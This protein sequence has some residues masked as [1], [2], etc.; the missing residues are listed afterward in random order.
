MASR[1]EALQ[2]SDSDGSPEKPTAPEPVPVEP[3]PLDD[4]GSLEALL[5]NQKPLREAARKILTEA[6]ASSE[7][8]E[9]DEDDDREDHEDGEPGA[10]EEEEQEEGRRQKRISKKALQRE[11]RKKQKAAKKLAV[12]EVVEGEDG[13]EEGEDATTAPKLSKAEKK[14]QQEL[15]KKLQKQQRQEEEKAETEKFDKGGY[16]FT[17]LSGKVL[18]RPASILRAPDSSMMWDIP[19]GFVPGMR[20]PAR[21]FADEV[22][23]Q[24]VLEEISSAG[25]GF[26]PAVQQLANVAT[27]PGI[28]GCSLGMPD[29][30]SGYGF[31]VGSV[32]AIDLSR[33]EA[34]VSPGGVGFDINCGVRLLR[35]NLSEADLKGNKCA[36]L[37]TAVFEAVPAGVG[38]EGNVFG[39]KGLGDLKAALKEGMGWAL[40]K[41]LCWPKDLEK[42]EENGAMPDA[43]PDAVSIRALKRGSPQLGTLGSGNH[44]L[45]IQVVDEVMDQ[46]AATAMGLQKGQV[47]VMIHCGSR[48]L[49]HQLCTD[50]LQGME[51]AM[52][53]QGISIPDRQLCCVRANSPQGEQYLRGMAAAANYAFVNRTIIAHSVRQAFSNVFGRDPKDLGMHM[54]YDVSHNI[55]KKEWHVDPA[56]GQ[57]K[58]TLVHRKGATRAFPPGHEDLPECY[59]GCGQ[60]VLIGGSMGTCSYVLVGGPR[61]MELSFGSTCHGAGRRL[62]RAESMRTLSSSDVLA[63]LKKQGIE[64]RVT[65]QKL[66]A[67]EADES[68]KDVNS[69]V[70]TCHEV[71][72]SK[73]VARMRP[74][75]VIKG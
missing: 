49:G 34:V 21:F 30:H 6:A 31:A 26:L 36:R 39:G 68:Y 67:E 20:A 69:V 25:G 47:C 32:A 63:K 56:D 15:D 54:V 64:V 73:L 8:E 53:Q 66:I 43:D 16:N 27:L 5:P 4:E 51:S 24:L 19:L 45:E 17:K 11:E 71:G 23:S 52:K 38:A 28:M 7:D 46:D 22:L 37:A 59:R 40:R 55:A 61:S 2:E 35:T 75:A 65:S 60:P 42:T 70:K 74:V 62:S 48:G 18:L 12:N 33:P 44:Y 58:P 72:I 3:G 13:G 50:Y 41:G 9:G 1:F 10:D 29:I 57:K 14:R